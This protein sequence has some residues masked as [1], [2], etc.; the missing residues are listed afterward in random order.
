VDDGFQGRPFP[1]QGLGSIGILPDAGLRQF[2][3][4]LGE[5]VLALGK[6]KD[7]P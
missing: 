3:L 4:Y 7:T 6:V 5:A 1:A 2:Q